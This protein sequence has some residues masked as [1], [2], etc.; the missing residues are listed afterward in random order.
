MD[1]KNAVW[2]DLRVSA[3]MVRV[4]GSQY[5][6]APEYVPI[7]F[8]RER[9]PS[10]SGLV[11]YSFGYGRGVFQN[12]YFLKLRQPEMTFMRHR[13]AHGTVEIHIPPGTVDDILPVALGVFHETL[14]TVHRWFAAFR[15]QSARSPEGADTALHGNPCPAQGGNVFAP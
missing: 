3:T 15:P 6:D 11:G 9:G 1:E 2:D 14:V 4:K 7:L 5:S 12:A 10:F 8:N 13:F